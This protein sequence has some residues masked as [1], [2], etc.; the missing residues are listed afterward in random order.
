[1]LRL[2]RTH[3]LRRQDELSG[4]WRFTP[5]SGPKAGQT[6]SV[7]VPS[8]WECLPGFENYRGKAVYDTTFRGGGHI[9]LVFKGVSHTA[10]VFFDEVKAAAHYNAYTPFEAVI[11]NV[12]EGE[13]RVSVVVSNEH[14]EA[15]SL[16]IPNDYY[17]YGGIS[18][19]AAVEYVPDVYITH[20]HAT[21][22]L[23]GGA[24]SLRLAVGLRNV[25]GLRRVVSAASKL[26]AV[27]HTF[28]PASVA[29]GGE[30]TI[31]AEVP[32]PGVTPYEPDN[33]VLYTLRTT[34]SID[35]GEPCDDLIERV[36]FRTVEVSGDKILWNGTPLRVKG[37]CRHEDHPHY[38]CAL[39]FQAMALDIAKMKDMGAN[40]VRT[41]HYPNDELFLDLCDEAGLL[42]WEEN[43]GRGLT[44]DDMR[45][46]NFRRQ[47]EDCNREM[48]YHHYNHPSIF[49]WGILNECASETEYGRDCYAE[50]LAQIRAL[51][52]SRPVSF[53]SC[54]YPDDISLGLVDVVSYNT[55]PRWYHDTPAAE[56]LEKL[57]N[58]VKTTEGGG[59]PFLITEVGAGGI[60]GYRDPA[61]KKW[62]EERHA[63]ILAE[64]LGAIL[65]S[66]AVSGVFIW[67]YCDIRVDESWAMKRPRTMNNKGVVDEY[68]RPKL[69]YETVRKI[70]REG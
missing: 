5:L 25:G 34:L 59:K 17:N 30:T 4:L 52:S 32:C 47:C 3:E 49:I 18:R 69:A 40:A 53:A 2:F 1:M 62:T 61:R 63:D 12:P 35:G 46:P 54:K 45:N 60:Y 38:G 7:A 43:H 65:G 6:Q 67:Q 13:H 48:V 27:R 28:E 33:P 56:H 9:R 8:C 23:S 39:P 51:D 19:P 26:G 68:R 57:L 66:E 24:W 64:Q 31:T 20:V 10:D 36:G 42:V 16:H 15:S 21:P 50:Q 44:E 55:Y 11:P 22:L 14:G 70:F 58:W 41:S 29:A 37:F